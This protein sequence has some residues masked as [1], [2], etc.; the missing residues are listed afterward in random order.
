MNYEVKIRHCCRNCHFL[1]KELIDCRHVSNH[2]WSAQDRKN[3][4]IG[5]M[6]SAKCAEGI[7][8]TG[9]NPELKLHL[10]EILL[11]QRQDRC[12][13]VEVQEGMLFETARKLHRIR[14]ESRNLKKSYRY[15][16]LGLWIATL[17]LFMNLVYSILRD[18]NGFK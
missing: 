6:Y 8:D 10:K 15:T 18:F 5:D 12:F 13:F 17:G 11:K 1:A 3:L 16:Q 4:Q 9:V 7:W 14:S 2:S